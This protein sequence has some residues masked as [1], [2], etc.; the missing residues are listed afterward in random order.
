LSVAEWHHELAHQRVV[1]LAAVAETRE[2][3]TGHAVDREVSALPHRAIVDHVVGFL[4]ERSLWIAHANEDAPSGSTARW[5]ERGIGT[6]AAVDLCPSQR[7]GD[8]IDAHLPG[9]DGLRDTR[10]RAQGSRD[11]ADEQRTPG[12]GSHRRKR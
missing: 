3:D 2:G 1:P 12:E 5:H 11:H 9:V 10:L 6:G 4:F 7:N 8:A